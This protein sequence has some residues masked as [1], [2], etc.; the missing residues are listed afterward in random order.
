MTGGL[1]YPAFVGQE[2]QANDQRVFP[3]RLQGGLQPLA[4]EASPLERGSIQVRGVRCAGSGARPWDMSSGC[5]IPLLVDD[6]RGLYYP[7]YIGDYNNP[8]EESRKKNNQYNGM[9]EGF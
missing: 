2:H 1:L 4:P 3:G 8:I 6:Y 5:E 7:L 9:R